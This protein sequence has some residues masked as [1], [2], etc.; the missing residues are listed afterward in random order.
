ME[1]IPSTYPGGAAT[2]ES[3]SELPA[4]TGSSLPA[5]IRRL[6]RDDHRRRLVIQVRPKGRTPQSSSGRGLF[7]NE[8]AY[9]MP[10]GAN[11]F[12][13]P[14]VTLSHVLQNPKLHIA[15]L[16]RAYFAQFPENIPPTEPL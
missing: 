10:Q 16:R 8:E 1:C 13:P 3:L 12:D 5:R 7:F 14:D 6:P 9:A 4:A 15:G 11:F 2:S